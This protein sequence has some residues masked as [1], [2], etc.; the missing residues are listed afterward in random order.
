MS[1]RKKGGRRSISKFRAG[2]TIRFANRIVVWLLK[3]GVRLGPNVLL[4]VPGR[5]SGLP[6]A[7]PVAIVEL[8]G[9]CYL[10]SPYGQV[11]W[12][13]NLRAAGT[14][15]IRRGRRTEA[16]QATELT[17]A[18]AAPVIKAVVSM[19]PGMLRRFYAVTPEA[20]LKDF[21]Q[22]AGNHPTFRLTPA[23]GKAAAG[24]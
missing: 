7:V 9:Q 2:T 24:A 20:P 17:A 15:M 16:V 22:E 3:A 6:R 19:A 10:Q 18:E 21:E 23:P 11:E 8:E 13:R 12:V 1:K 5:K 4:T 14:G